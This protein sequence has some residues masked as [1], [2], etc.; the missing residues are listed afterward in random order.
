MDSRMWISFVLQVIASVLFSV[1]IWMMKK[2][3]HNNLMIGITFGVLV[4]TI[5][6]ARWSFL[7]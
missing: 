4:T 5:S 7:V 3:T 6:F 2:N 1:S